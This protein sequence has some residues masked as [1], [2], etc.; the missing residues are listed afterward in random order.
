MRTPRSRRALSATF[1]GLLLFGGVAACSDEDS[2]GGSVDEEL[3]EGG[4]Q[5]EEE[6]PE[7]E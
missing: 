6:L 3:D 5:L 1:A 4:E 2:D 7:E